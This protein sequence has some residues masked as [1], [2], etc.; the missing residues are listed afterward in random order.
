LKQQVILGALAGLYHQWEKELRDFI[1]RELMHDVHKDEA[2]KLAWR[3]PI[4]D[5]F[6]LLT[7]FGWEVRT[8]PFFPLIDACRLIVNVQK[9]GKGR[10]LE[11]LNRDYPRYLRDPLGRGLPTIIP[12][13][14]DHTL[15]TVSEEHFAEIAQALR[16]FWE[17]FPERLYL[18]AI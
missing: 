2:M 3:G 17:E 4:T 5:V 8:R 7:E 9:H 15:L 14:L 12:D 10:S 11:E 1:E 13:Y 6:D 16:T 18:T